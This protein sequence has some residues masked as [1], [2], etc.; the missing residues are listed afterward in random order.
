MR[1]KPDPECYIKAMQQFNMQPHECLI[2][3]DAPIGIEA[4]SASGAN[5]IIVK[6]FFHGN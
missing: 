1:P 5:Y 2:F 4:A 6:E 3:E